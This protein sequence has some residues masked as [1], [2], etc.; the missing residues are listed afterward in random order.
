MLGPKTF[1]N[2]RHLQVKL[3]LRLGLKP[4]NSAN[5]LETFLVTTK[6]SMNSKPKLIYPFSIVKRAKNLQIRSHE[7]ANDYYA[8]GAEINHFQELLKS[9]EIP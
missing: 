4:L 6:R 5:N 3:R 2:S 9:A 1:T 7:L 8:I